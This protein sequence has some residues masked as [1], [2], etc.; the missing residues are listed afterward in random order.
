[1]A[2]FGKFT[3]A[4]GVSHLVLGNTDVT[5]GAGDYEAGSLEEAEVLIFHAGQTI[6]P[7]GADTSVPVVVIIEMPD[8]VEPADHAANQG[9]ATPPTVP[10]PAAGTPATTTH[11][12]DAPA[13]NEPGVPAATAGVGSTAPAS[14]PPQEAAAQPAAAAPP[15]D[16]AP[17]A[18]AGPASPPASPPVAPPAPAPAPPA[19]TAPATVTAPDAAK[20]APPAPAPDAGTAPQAP[21]APGAAP[22]RA[23][24]PA[25]V[26]AEADLVAAE[27]EVAAAKVAE[28]ARATFANGPAG[29]PGATPP[30][31]AK[32]QRYTFGPDVAGG[33]P[34]GD[35]ADNGAWKATGERAADPP[36]AGK[37][38]YVHPPGVVVEG[39]WPHYDGTLI[40]G[41][42]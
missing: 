10:G 4:D 33:P 13:G 20:P 21:A 23:G 18:S 24:G 42:K 8:P 32:A 3:I 40:P 36:V 38:V 5:V 22:G 25:M 7:A 39:D 1:M 35:G 17:P 16:N 19:Q 34:T 6:Q 31:A 27:A 2:R 30:A 11:G 29:A 26:K 12:A 15:V 28:D 41:A 14:S 37:P 9:Q